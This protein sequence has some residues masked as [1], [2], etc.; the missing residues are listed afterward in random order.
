[1]ENIKH[2]DNTIIQIGDNAPN[3]SAN[4]TIGKINLTDFAGKWVI[5]F[6]HPGDFTPVCST[7]FLAFT[8]MYNEFKKR[9]CVLIGLSTDSNSSHLAWINDLYNISNMEIPFPII[10]DKNMNIS[11]MYNMI[12]PNCSNTSTIRNVYIICPEQKIQCILSYPMNIGRNIVEILRIIDALQV[13]K[14]NNV[15][16]PANWIPGLPT[17]NYSPQ[18][19]KVM[20]DTLKKHS[21]SC[22]SFYLCYNKNNI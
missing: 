1:M 13:S 6:C 8:E 22:Y 18:T 10:E 19:Q 12:A 5:L 7:E 9:N 3:F 21:D 4:S 14:K 20:V 17:L 15:A 2:T 11:K 16:I